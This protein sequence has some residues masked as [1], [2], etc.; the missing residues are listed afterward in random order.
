MGQS[1]ALSRLID[2][3]I[4]I[5]LFEESMIRSEVHS[6]LSAGLTPNACDYRL[7]AIWG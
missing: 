1:Q 3:A 7:E 4:L 6:A 5:Q 2:N